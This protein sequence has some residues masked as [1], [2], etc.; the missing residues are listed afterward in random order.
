MGRQ[1]AAR[2]G[3]H[4]IGT[5][6]LLGTAADE[7]RVDFGDAVNRLRKTSFRASDALLRS[8]LARYSRRT[9]EEVERD[10]DE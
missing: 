4:V 2:R 3:L 6:G 1:E 9:P 5:L 8:L 10:G 7:G